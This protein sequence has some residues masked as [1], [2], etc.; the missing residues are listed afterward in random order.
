MYHF[1]K[2]KK[3][4][5]IIKYVILLLFVGAH[6]ILYTYIRCS[7]FFA[8]F[9]FIRFSI[10]NTNEIFKNYF[11]NVPSVSNISDPSGRTAH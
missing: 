4:H 8:M 1:I 3:K 11:S 9:F 5:N 7:T 10:E 6:N 2:K